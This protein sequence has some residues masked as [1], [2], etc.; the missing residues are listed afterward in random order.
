MFSTFEK[1]AEFP[2]GRTG[3]LRHWLQVGKQSFQMM[4]LLLFCSFLVGGEGKI[5]EGVGFHKV[6]AHT[7]GYNTRSL[8]IAFIGN[9]QGAFLF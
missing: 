5:Y 7:R 8:G 3:I 1:Y 6:G 4:I 2:Y 9:F